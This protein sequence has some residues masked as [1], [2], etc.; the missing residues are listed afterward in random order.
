MGQHH[1][2]IR[3]T[4]VKIGPCEGALRRFRNLLG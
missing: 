3:A 1:W 2:T 4:R